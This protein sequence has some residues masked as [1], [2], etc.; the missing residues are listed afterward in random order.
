MRYV[1][2]RNLHWI[3]PG[4]RV[5]LGNIAAVV[6]WKTA[7]DGTFECNTGGVRGPDVSVGY[8]V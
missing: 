1:V 2:V 7:G 3:E 5:N 8:G 6:G 4:G